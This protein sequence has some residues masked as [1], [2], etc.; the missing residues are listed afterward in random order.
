M[1]MHIQ[2][3]SSFLQW[4][5][6]WETREVTEREPSPNEGPGQV[7]ENGPKVKK[8]KSSKIQ[9]NKQKE[10]DKPKDKRG[11]NDLKRARGRKETN[12]NNT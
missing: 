5:L 4:E 7:S 10:E 6:E 3:E 12:K 8:D 9:K 2:L 1:A 11:E